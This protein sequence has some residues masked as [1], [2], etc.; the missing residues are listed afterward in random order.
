[1]QMKMVLRSLAQ[2]ECKDAHKDRRDM[3]FCRLVAE[4]HLAGKFFEAQERP[5]SDDEEKEDDWLNIGDARFESD[6]ERRFALTRFRA[7]LCIVQI[8]CCLID[9][10]GVAYYSA[11]ILR[12]SIA[13]APLPGSRYRTP[14]YN[15]PSHVVVICFQ[16]LICDLLTFVLQP[17]IRRR[18]SIGI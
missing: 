4:F 17:I 13:A 10:R 18:C 12:R 14:S 3:S 5:R 11:K 9:Y 2:D 8:D 15:F 7:E 1:M 6:R 16:L